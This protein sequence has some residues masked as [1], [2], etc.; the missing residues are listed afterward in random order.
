MES[1][2]I[3]G[4]NCLAFTKS[5]GNPWISVKSWPLNR[6]LPILY[7]NRLWRLKKTS[8]HPVWWS[9][10]PEQTGWTPESQLTSCPS[11]PLSVS[12]RGR[13]RSEGMR[14][15]VLVRSEKV[16]LLSL[17]QYCFH[18]NRIFVKYFYLKKRMKA[19]QCPKV[20]SCWTITTH[21]PTRSTHWR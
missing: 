5:S 9:H 19:N 21:S 10:P 11:C 16:W 1:P 8:S 14:H 13:K 18:L 3:A 4:G 2:Y 6:F 12:P 17:N 7:L 15:Q 20:L